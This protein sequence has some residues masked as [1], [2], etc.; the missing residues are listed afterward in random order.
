MP[1]LIPRHR[2]KA[3]SGP[4]ANALIAWIG[5]DPYL[6]DAAVTASYRRWMALPMPANTRSAGAAVVA[7]F[8]LACGAV[9][10]ITAIISHGRAAGQ[11]KI[12]PPLQFSEGAAVTPGT[13]PSPTLSTGSSLAP[14]GMAPMIADHA[15][16]Q[17]L[18]VPTTAKKVDQVTGDH[19]RDAAGYPSPAATATP[20]AAIPA[21]EPSKVSKAADHVQRVTTG[22][23][24]ATSQ[25]GNAGKPSDPRPL[26]AES[27]SDGPGTPNA[28]SPN[29]DKP[30]IP[31]A[32]GNQDGFGD[33]A[34]QGDPASTIPGTHRGNGKTSEPDPTDRLDSAST[35]GQSGSGPLVSP[36][37]SNSGRGSAP[38]RKPNSGAR[39]AIPSSSGAN[40]PPT[41]DRLP[42]KALDQ[43]GGTTAPARLSI[44]A[45]AT[46]LSP[47]QLASPSATPLLSRPA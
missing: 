13:E 11:H 40:Q 26:L 47:G 19:A 36:Q 22:K 33:P 45:S 35:Q 42:A 8:V 46:V 39:A 14:A 25:P 43:T 12:A 16:P 3:G 30:A 15:A 18:A 38:T 23:L 29:P 31:G 37:R 24:G 28:G 4:P 20:A 41:R 9:L 27:K 17:P 32:S 21:G 10:G 34:H 6:R 44:S 2:R 5:S 1:Q 7:C